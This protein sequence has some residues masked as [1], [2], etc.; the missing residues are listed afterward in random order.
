MN[1]LATSL[2]KSGKLESEYKE[3]GPFD[4]LDNHIKTGHRIL[5]L[6]TK[7]ISEMGTYK[8]ILEFI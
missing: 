8:M 4:C 7:L 5:E 6:S 3:G 1:L 2:G